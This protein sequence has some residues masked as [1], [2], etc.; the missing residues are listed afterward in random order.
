MFQRNVVLMLLVIVI[1]SGCSKK[2][3][4]PVEGFTL[5][6]KVEDINVNILP[7]AELPYTGTTIAPI[8]PYYP[9]DDE[10]IVV[11]IYEGE[12][13]YH[14]LTIAQRMFHF[15]DSY[16]Q[17]Q[18]PVYLERTEQFALKLIE[19]AEEHRGGYFYPIPFD[20]PLHGNKEEVM[21]APWYSGIA[22]GRI[23]SIFSRLYTVSGKPEYLEAARK[24]YYSLIP[25]EN[26]PFP[27][28]A[29]FDDSTNY[30]WV[31]EYPWKPIT[32]VLN[33]FVVA[34]FGL[35]DY[36]LVTEDEVCKKY[37]QA[38]LTTLKDHI[39]QYRVPGGVSYYCLLHKVQS[40]EYHLMHIDF[41]NLV[42]RIT[43]DN[44]FKVM[45]DSFYQDYHQ[46]S[47]F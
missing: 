15:L 20:F 33:G 1:F 10:G 16:V 14:P 18:N 3:T 11:F 17:T 41:L 22:H 28:V 36:Y 47:G 32:K 29:I 4:E 42:Y 37:L 38:A 21:V 26:D 39:E 12:P 30:Y 34:I 24:T 27:W 44:Y 23:L 2:S 13:Y 31:E 9:H 19:L 46:E 40:I 6:C 8:E 43:S 5:P 35:Y 45:A 7:Y 25:A